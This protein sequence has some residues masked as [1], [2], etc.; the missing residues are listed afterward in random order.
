MLQKLPSAP[1]SYLMTMRLCIV[2]CTFLHYLL[3][4]SDELTLMFTSIHGKRNHLRWKRHSLHVPTKFR[5]SELGM[6]LRFCWTCMEISVLAQLQFPLASRCRCQNQILL[7]CLRPHRDS[8][9]T[10]DL[11]MLFCLINYLLLFVESTRY[12]P[13]V[14]R[15][16]F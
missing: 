16:Q 12:R 8:D 9:R 10:L 7:R 3:R 2:T 5:R 15:N 6:R 14:Q 1:S 11:K 4:I 13:P